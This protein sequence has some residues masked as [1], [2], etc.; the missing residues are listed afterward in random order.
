MDASEL[1]QGF[2]AGLA[3][4]HAAQFVLACREVKMTADL[5][6]KVML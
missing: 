5:V 6:V 3:W 4:A 1:A 2:S